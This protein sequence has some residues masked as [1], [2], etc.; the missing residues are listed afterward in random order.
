MLSIS[1]ATVALIGLATVTLGTIGSL[2]KKREEAFKQ[3]DQ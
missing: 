2:L 3:V 1:I